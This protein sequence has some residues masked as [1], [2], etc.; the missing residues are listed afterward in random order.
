[1]RSRTALIAGPVLALVLALILTV[2]GVGPLAADEPAQPGEAAPTSPLTTASNGEAPDDAVPGGPI[3][4]GKP[5]PEATGAAA[6][7]AE[8]EHAAETAEVAPAGALEVAVGKKALP[9]VERTLVHLI[10]LQ[11]SGSTGSVDES[12]QLAERSCDALDTRKPLV[13]ALQNTC[14]DTITIVKLT[15]GIGARC[16]T[17]TKRCATSAMRLADASR[18]YVRARGAFARSLREQV[19]PGVCRKALLPTSGEL[20]GMRAVTRALRQLAAAAL[21]EDPVALTQ[22]ASDVSAAGAAANADA[23]P[24]IAVSEI[25]RAACQLPRFPEVG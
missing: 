11:H 19:A 15:T 20:A 9:A 16:T 12:V 21:A 6:N 8:A 17:P 14:A 24:A 2:G 18:G 13:A 3:K 1:M 7:V 4:G 22:A 23:R 25:M 10:E 5:S